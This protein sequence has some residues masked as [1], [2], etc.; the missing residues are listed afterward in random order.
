MGLYAVWFTMWGCEPRWAGGLWFGFV[1]V[2]WFLVCLG[3]DSV[4]FGFGG[5]EVYGGSCIVGWGMVIGSGCC[6]Y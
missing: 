2:M 5:I 4:R 1:L 3:C 6:G